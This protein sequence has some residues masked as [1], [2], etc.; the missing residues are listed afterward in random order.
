MWDELLHKKF[1]SSIFDFGLKSILMNIL[2]LAIS[3]KWILQSLN[4]FPAELTSENIK[5]HL[6]KYRLNS[7]KSRD[8]FIQCYNETIRNLDSQPHVYIKI[9]QNYYQTPSTKFNLYPFSLD[10]QSSVSDSF[11]DDNSTSPTVDNNPVS[12]YQHSLSNFLKQKEKY[13]ESLKQLIQ[14]YRLL[15]NN[16]TNIENKEEQNTNS[17]SS[18]NIIQNSNSEN[19]VQDNDSKITLPASDEKLTNLLPMT[20]SCI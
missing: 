18:D 3:P 10:L 6:Q 4:V 20:L 5:S 7:Q 2:L 8:S 11:E 9:I 17:N 14:S 1:L 15:M 19:F 16:T 13:D 12:I